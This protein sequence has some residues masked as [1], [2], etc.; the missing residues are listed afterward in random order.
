MIRV[1]GWFYVFTGIV[2]AIS[3]ALQVGLRVRAEGAR[4]LLAGAGLFSVISLLLGLL[5]AYY[6]AFVHK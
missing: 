4:R 1:P 5:V 2:L 3:G 6:G